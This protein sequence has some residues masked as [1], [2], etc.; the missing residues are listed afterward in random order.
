MAAALG[1]FDGV[2]RGHGQVIRPVLDF[3]RRVNPGPQGAGDRDDRPKTYS[4][5]VTFSPHPQEFFS[6][7]VRSLLT[8]TSE[9]VRVLEKLGVEQLVQLPFDQALASLTP[10]VFVE[11][12]LIQGLG[13]KYIS[14]GQDF[15]F[16]RQRAGT[17]ADLRSIAE[18]YG[19]TVETTLLKQSEG[20]RISSSR[21]RE[22]LLAGQVAVAN[23]LLG[24]SYRLQGCV[25]SGQQLGRT[26]G[27]PT[28]NLGV[29]PPKFLPRHG[30]YAVW[31]SSLAVPGLDKPW[32]GV[33]NIGDRPTVNGQSVT[34]EVHLLDWSLDLYDQGLTVELVEFLRPQQKFE[35]LEAL[36]A[37]IERDCDRARASLASR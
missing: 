23:D 37:Q 5:V 2:H 25:V 26:L 28:A 10:E 34:V 19:V 11:Q 13:C 36:R 12:I 17:A 8:P 7:E 32:P 1:N 9:K 24:Y 20:S 21:V 18:P 15:C 31:V 22:A 29:L 4:T 30:V 16:G 27:F 33:M 35:G 3:C 14:V 6:G